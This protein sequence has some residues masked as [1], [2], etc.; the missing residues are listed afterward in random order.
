MTDADLLAGMFY[1]KSL[2]LAIFIWLF[3]K[4]EINAELSQIAVVS[5]NRKRWDAAANN[6]L[7]EI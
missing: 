2:K 3:I 6:H 5:I 4:S 1:N 7:R